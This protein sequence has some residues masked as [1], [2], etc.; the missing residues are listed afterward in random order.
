[1][2]VHLVWAE[3]ADRVIGDGRTIPWHI[4]EDQANFK[5]RTMGGTV[6]MGRATW[7]SLPPRVRPLAGRRNVVLSRD[8]AFTA[9][10]ATVV[11]AIDEVDTATGDLW[12]IGGAAVYE[13]FLPKA[14][15]VL[16][17]RV[18]L[19]VTGDVRAPR[20]GPEWVLRGDSG[21]QTSRNGPRFVIE[22]LSRGPQLPR[23]S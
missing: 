7:E 18:D 16:R 15:H 12:V 23:S 22:E 8:P 20:L 19:R 4:P 2:T 1:V 21:W 3:A 5:R 13:A 14:D 17:T 11:H 9:E 10:G 6:V